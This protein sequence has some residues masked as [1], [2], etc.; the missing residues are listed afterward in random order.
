MGKCSEPCQGILPAHSFREN[1]AIYISPKVSAKYKPTAAKR[2]EEGDTSED[3]WK[4]K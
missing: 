2:K 3:A 4:A 1:G